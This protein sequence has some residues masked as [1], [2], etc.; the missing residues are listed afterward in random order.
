MNSNAPAS[1][2][3]DLIKSV[4]WLGIVAYVVWKVFGLFQGATLT[5]LFNLGEPSLAGLAFGAC[6]VGLI[7]RSPQI[8]ESA[9]MIEANETRTVVMSF[10]FV[11]V[12]MG[13]YYILR[14]VRDSMASDWTDPEIS[15]IWIFQFFFSLILV[16]AYGAACSRIR[17]RF[18]VPAV[19]IFYAVSFVVFSAGAPFIEGFSFDIDF[20]I[21]L[22]FG[23]SIPIV[24]A[25]VDADKIFY[26]WVSLFSLFHLSVFWSFM[27]DTFTGPQSKRLFPFIAA[28][29]SAGA[30][31]GPLIAAVFARGIGNTNL[32]LIAA[33]VLLI[34][35]PLIFFIQRLKVS[36]LHNENV[37]A[38][39]SAAKIGG[40]WWKGF[41]DFISSPYM[42][43]IGL[44]ILIYTGIQAF[45]YL[46]TN[47]LLR[48][49]E[50]RE[51]RTTI[52]GVRDAFVNIL[53]FGL[54][55]FVT[56][57]I[58]RKLGMPGTLALV[59]FIAVAG[60]VIIAFAPILIVLL[61]VDIARRAGNYGIMRPAREM[62]FTSVDRETRF[63]TKP[64]V[65]VAVYRAGDAWWG[66]IFAWLSTGIGLGFVAMAWVGAGLA[67]VWAASGVYLGRVFNRREASAAEAPDN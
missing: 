10:L 44:F 25:D 20:T 29:A 9:T 63:K 53:T 34:I 50:E 35:T 39:L 1:K 7:L 54:G 56:N 32:M 3:L 11:L 60:F 47:D 43:A 48:I 45:I 38:D 64:V 5:E 30:T 19:Y 61:A 15:M 13:A 24:L 17:F 52:L 65:D 55:L 18:L 42:L 33:L 23:A 16:A 22:P 26:I 6:C 57:R 2:S 58:V 59:P 49:Y 8:R 51:Q 27:A 37:S 12:V 46:E 21:P 67:A 41:G 66:A 40:S 14:A 4:C 36:D 31:A 62:L 28:G